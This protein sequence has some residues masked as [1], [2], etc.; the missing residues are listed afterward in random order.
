MSYYPFLFVLVVLCWPAWANG[1]RQS[2]PLDLFSKRRA[3]LMALPIT[4]SVFR[5]RCVFCWMDSS[6]GKEIVLGKDTSVQLL[7]LTDSYESELS[8]RDRQHWSQILSSP[9]QLG[10]CQQKMRGRCSGAGIQPGKLPA[11]RLDRQRGEGTTVDLLP[12]P[13]RGGQLRRFAAP[14]VEPQPRRRRTA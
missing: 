11:I 9:H 10:P 2:Q 3:C 5:W 1:E 12:F 6:L 8:E 13:A 7:T 14:S 4:S